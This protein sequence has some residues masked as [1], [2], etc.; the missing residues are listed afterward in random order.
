MNKKKGSLNQP[1]KPRWQDPK[2]QYSPKYRRHWAT[3]RSRIVFK[4]ASSYL[5]MRPESRPSFCSVGTSVS[6]DKHQSIGKC[7][8]GLATR[9]GKTERADKVQRQKC[10][11]RLPQKG[12][13]GGKVTV[14]K[15]TT[16]VWHKIVCKVGTLYNASDHA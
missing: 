15:V 4:K 14:G 13:K 5:R 2:N 6:F 10:H 16:T 3:L 1:W 12:R 7:L 8:F 11:P 9:Q